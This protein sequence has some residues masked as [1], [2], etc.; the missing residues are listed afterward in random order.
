[1]DYDTDAYDNAGGDGAEWAELYDDNAQ[2]TYW[3]NNQTGEATW[4]APPGFDLGPPKGGDWASYMD[5]EGNE[6][7]YNTATG[8]TSWEDPALGGA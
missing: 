2:A 3:F 7:W 5:A 8:E 6:Y 4:T 1:M